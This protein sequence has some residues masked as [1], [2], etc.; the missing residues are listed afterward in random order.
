MSYPTQP[1]SHVSKAATPPIEKPYPECMSGIPN[2][3]PAIDGRVATTA[4]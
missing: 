2:D 3:P 4:I 1:G